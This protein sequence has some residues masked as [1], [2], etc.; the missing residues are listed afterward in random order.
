MSE[1]PGPNPNEG[2]DPEW[3]KIRDR[4]PVEDFGHRTAKGLIPNVVNMAIRSWYMDVVGVE[5]VI[6]KVTTKLAGRRNKI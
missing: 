2:I 1:I 3:V 5:R 4:F 6:H